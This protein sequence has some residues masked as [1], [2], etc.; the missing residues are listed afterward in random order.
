M[1]ESDPERDAA[2]DAYVQAQMLEEGRRALQAQERGG[3]T[4]DLDNTPAG[5][6]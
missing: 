6:D 2:I 4:N 1:S 5:P 3:S